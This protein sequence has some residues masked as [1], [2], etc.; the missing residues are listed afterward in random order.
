M[1][2]PTTK[3]KQEFERLEAR[4]SNEKKSFLK[5]AADLVGRSLTDFVVNS[6]YEAATRVI[7][8]QEQIKLSIEDSNTFISALQNAPT[9]SNVLIAAAKK[10][11]KEIISK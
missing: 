5:H 3:H 9:P 6:A 11:K 8:E 1:P 2:I 10:Y 4:I 7:K